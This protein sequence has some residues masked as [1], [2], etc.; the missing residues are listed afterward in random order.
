MSFSQIVA[1]A[2]DPSRTRVSYRRYGLNNELRR[3][4]IHRF[5]IKDG[6]TLGM[7]MAENVSGSNPLLRQLMNRG[8]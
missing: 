6:D 3:P 7:L 8:N 1:N 5:N 4:I 2:L